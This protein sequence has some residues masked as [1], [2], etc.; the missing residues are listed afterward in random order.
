MMKLSWALLVVF[1]FGLRAADAPRRDTAK[2]KT[3][4]PLAAAKAGR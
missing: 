2:D 4:E 3:N 1:A